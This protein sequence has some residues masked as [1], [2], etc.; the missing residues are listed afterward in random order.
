MRVNAGRRIL[1]K[2]VMYAGPPNIGLSNAQKFQATSMLQEKGE[3]KAKA[4]GEEKEKAEQKEKAKAEAKEAEATKEK[5]EEMEMS[6][7]GKQKN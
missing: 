4:K 5:V 7:A 3:E 2:S 6:K 1:L